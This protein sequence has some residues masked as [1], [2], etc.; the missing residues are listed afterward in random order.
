[1]TS[2]VAGNRYQ[3]QI[4]QARLDCIARSIRRW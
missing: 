1:M 4:D 2:G 3:L